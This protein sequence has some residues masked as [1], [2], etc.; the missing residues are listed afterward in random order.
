M[1]SES[2]ESAE[3]HEQRRQ[4]RQ[5]RQRMGE[6]VRETGYCRVRVMG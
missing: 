5:R 3:R 6:V 4:R 2:A 1:V